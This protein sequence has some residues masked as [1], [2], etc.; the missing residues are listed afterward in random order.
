MATHT[1]PANG[2]LY[3]TIQ[4]DELGYILQRVSDKF[5]QLYQLY[6]IIEYTA[7]IDKNGNLCQHGFPTVIASYKVTSI[8]PENMGI[9]NYFKYKLEKMGD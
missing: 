4:S 2:D 9:K 5:K 7:Y 6:D 1:I 3:H 8:D